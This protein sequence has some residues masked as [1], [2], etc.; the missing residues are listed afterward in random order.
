MNESWI[1]IPERKKKPQKA[2][3]EGMLLLSIV[4][5]MA[6]FVGSFLFLKH[7]AAAVL[8]P[9]SQATTVDSR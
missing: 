5:L 2:T 4:I 6:L 9:L 8:Y 3:M 7:P 1:E